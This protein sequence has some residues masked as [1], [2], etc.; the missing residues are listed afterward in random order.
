M[1]KPPVADGESEYLWL[2]FAFAGTVTVWDPIQRHLE[3]GPRTFTV[4]PSVRVVGLTAGI[5][6]TLGGYMERS[7]ES[8]SRWMVT[9]FRLG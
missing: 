2:P 4:A 8:A 9:Q 7:V 6:V 1:A 5:H 3:L